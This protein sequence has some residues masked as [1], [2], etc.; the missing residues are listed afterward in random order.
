MSPKE[1]RKNGYRIRP[2][3]PQPIP[4][5]PAGFR[6]SIPLRVR[7]QVLI[8][9]RGLD[10]DDGEPL[11]A[12][13]EGVDFDHRP[14]LQARIWNPDTEDTIPPSNH[15]DHI[16]ARRPE[17]HDAASAADLRIEAK[18]RRLRRAEEEHRQ[19]V[20]GRPCGGKRLKPQWRAWHWR[21]R[22]AAKTTRGREAAREESHGACD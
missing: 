3:K 14:P 6:K 1:K 15:P 18:V 13:R 7:Y 12:I 8:Q 11:D 20:G 17:A 22:R 2:A 21:N 4:L 10:P 5:P 16:I 19:A 9:Q